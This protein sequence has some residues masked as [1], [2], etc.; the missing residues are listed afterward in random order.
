M[1]YMHDV[2]ACR[3]IHRLRLRACD[4]KY[5]RHSLEWFAEFTINHLEHVAC[6]GLPDC[7]GSFTDFLFDFWPDLPWDDRSSIVCRMVLD[8]PRL[9]KIAS[10][11]EAEWGIDMTAELTKG[12]LAD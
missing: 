9:T 2:E 3:K 6:W 8:D 1:F 11:I 10:T 5:E 7:Y 12:S 4:A